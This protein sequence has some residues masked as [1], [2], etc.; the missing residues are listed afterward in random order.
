MFYPDGSN[1][2]VDTPMLKTFDPNRWYH[3]DE[4]LT[5]TS[6]AQVTIAI[7]GTPALTTT[8]GRHC[9]SGAPFDGV[10]P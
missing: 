5:G 2:V 7:D 4:H 10:A 6:P 1:T 8:S 9:T 3:V